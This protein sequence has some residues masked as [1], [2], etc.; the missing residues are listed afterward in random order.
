[1]HA[2]PNNACK[3]NV[4]DGTTMAADKLVTLTCDN[5]TTCVHAESPEQPCGPYVVGGTY[6]CVGPDDTQVTDNR[7]VEVAWRAPEKSY[8]AVACAA[9]RS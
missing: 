8:V 2:T 5:Y 9:F 1:M 6:S 3:L 7:W 4:R